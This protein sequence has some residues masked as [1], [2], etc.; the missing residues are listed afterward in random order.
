VVGVLAANR[1]I[2]RIGLG[3]ELDKI[4]QT[5]ARATASP[6]KPRVVEKAPCHEIVITGDELNKPGKG[7]D[8]IPVPISTPGWDNAPYTTLVAIHYE[9]PGHRRPEHGQLSRPGEDAAAARHESVTRI[10]ARHLR[11]LA[12]IQE[13]RRE[14]ASRRRAGRAARNHLRLDAEDFGVARRIWMSP[15]VWSARR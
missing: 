14:D 3:C 12:E 9:R 5:W 13:A 2:Y 6:I 1:E 15:A 10:A 7:L 11:A 4:E 8:G